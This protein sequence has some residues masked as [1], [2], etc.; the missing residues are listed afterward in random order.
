MLLRSVSFWARWQITHRLANRVY[1]CSRIGAAW[2]EH[3][4]GSRGSVPEEVVGFSPWRREQAL[5]ADLQGMLFEL[6]PMSAEEWGILFEQAERYQE[7]VVVLSLD[8][9]DASIPTAAALADATSK[10]RSPKS[11]A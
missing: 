8:I 1:V 5:I 6:R 2:Y 11:P 4:F 9:F 10:P 7:K 3:Q